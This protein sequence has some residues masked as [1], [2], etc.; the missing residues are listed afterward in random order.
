MIRIGQTGMPAAAGR[1]EERLRA[2][3][4]Q[5]EGVF[6]QQMF[7]AMRDSVPGGGIVDGGAGEE[8]FTGL[9]DEHL[10]QQTAEGSGH[11]PGEALFH[12]LR[13]AWMGT[14]KADAAES[15]QSADAVDVNRTGFGT[16]ADAA[17]RGMEVV[18]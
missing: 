5:L 8:T 4:R 3:S 15:A 1:D 9:L 11:G 12:Q 18:R 7:K 6:V 17:G 16:A 2:A 10:A 14:Q 13:A